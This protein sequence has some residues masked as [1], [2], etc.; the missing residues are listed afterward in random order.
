MGRRALQHQILLHK[1]GGRHCSTKCCYINGEGGTA[2]P[3]TVT[4]MGRGALQHQI[5]LHKWGGG[6]CSTRQCCIYKRISVWFFFK[7]TVH[8]KG[9]TAT[10]DYLTCVHIWEGRRYQT[11]IAASNTFFLNG[12]GGTA[13]P[14]TL[15]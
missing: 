5:L 12:E 13:A 14:N 10:P 2:A 7:P 4:S 9:G 15:L 6:H 11:H 8:G 1:W 3:N